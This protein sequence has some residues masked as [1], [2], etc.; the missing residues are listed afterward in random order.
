MNEKVQPALSPEEW[1]RD[2]L[3]R[4]VILASQYTIYERHGL[5]AACLYEQSFG[6]ARED[7]ELLQRVADAFSGHEWIAPVHSLAARIEALL[8]PQEVA[9]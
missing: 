8:P 9:G 5:A 7:I 1:A 6:F 4:E 3:E 2:G